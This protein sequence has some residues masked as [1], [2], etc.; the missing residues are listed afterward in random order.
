[1]T[2]YHS[3]NSFTRRV[4][5]ASVDL[6]KENGLLYVQWAVQLEGFLDKIGLS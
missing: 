2:S 5:F 6:Q 3:S 4:L 1:M